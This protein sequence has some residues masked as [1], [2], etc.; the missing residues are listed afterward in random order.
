MRA[1]IS[2][3]WSRRRWGAGRIHSFHSKGTFRGSYLHWL[4][5]QEC[6]LHPVSRHCLVG[7]DPFRGTDTR[8]HLVGVPWGDDFRCICMSRLLFH[9]LSSFFN[10]SSKST[11]EKFPPLFERPSYSPE[12]SEIDSISSYSLWSFICL[13][14]RQHGIGSVPSRGARN[15]M[16][17]IRSPAR[18][19][20]HHGHRRH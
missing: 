2:A 5:W 9:H 8:M 16:V 1:K 19:Y 4:R 12:T 7:G 10:R 18:A 11:H 13:F 20:N 17:E 14:F 3:A 6:L 15:Q